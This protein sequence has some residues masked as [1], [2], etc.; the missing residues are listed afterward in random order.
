MQSESKEVKAIKWC[1]VILAAPAFVTIAFFSYGILFW[2]V[3]M[4]LH[5][6]TGKVYGTYYI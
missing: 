3:N 2:V 5:A 1:L 4:L 6:L